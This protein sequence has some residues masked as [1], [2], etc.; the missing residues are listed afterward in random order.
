MLFDLMASWRLMFWL[1]PLKETLFLPCLPLVAPLTSGFP[2]KESAVT[3]L[4]PVSFGYWNAENG[5]LGWTWAREWV[6]A[7][8]DLSGCLRRG[9][10]HRLE[11]EGANKGNGSSGTWTGIRSFLLSIPGQLHLG[12]RLFQ[13]PRN[14]KR[15]LGAFGGCTIRSD[16]AGMR[17]SASLKMNPE[18]TD[19]SR[20]SAAFGFLITR[21]CFESTIYIA[22]QIRLWEQAIEYFMAH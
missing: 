10:L 6:A 19:L 18:F 12:M 1:S 21:K 13:D 3:V 15:S 16:Y 2:W 17:Y 22:K 7:C 14:S 8:W 20:V 4:K 9:T 11:P 5:I